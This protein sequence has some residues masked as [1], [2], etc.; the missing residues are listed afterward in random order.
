MSNAPAPVIAPIAGTPALATVRWSGA[1]GAV[2]YAVMRREASNAVE[3]RTATPITATFWNDALSNPASVYH[4][5]VIAYQAD[6]S[7]GTS[8]WTS[9][10]PPPM[11]NPTGFAAR[12][13][14]P[15]EVMLTWQKVT[16]ASEYR[17]DG[18]GIPIAGVT[19]PEAFLDV[20]GLSAGTTSSWQVAAVYG[21]GLFDLTT[22]PTAS[23]TLPASPWRTVPWLTMPNGPGTA[24]DQ[25]AYYDEMVERWS[26]ATN[27]A[28]RC[29]NAEWLVS[30]FPVSGEFLQRWGYSKDI[31]GPTVFEATFAD[32]RDMGAGRHVLC[33]QY[34]PEV[35][36]GIPGL[37]IET[38]CWAST[39][40]PLPGAAGWGDPQQSLDAVLGGN[41]NRGWTFLRTGVK[42]PLFAA[43]EGLPGSQFSVGYG[44]DQYGTPKLES[45]FDA[46][47]PKA[48][49]NA[50]LAC[51]GGR[52]DPAS[53]KVADASL[54]PLDPSALIFPSKAGLTRQDQEESIRNI[55]MIVLN[56]KPSPAV[57]AYIR[58]LYRGTPE[59]PGTTA[60][61][62]YVPTGWSHAPDLYRKVVKPYCQGC[63]L[64][65]T[66]RTD[67]ATYQNFV[68]LKGFIQAL[69]CGQHS[70][71]HAEAPFLGFWR[72]GQG[73]SLPEYMM[74]AL[75]LG[76]CTP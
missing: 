20:P 10:T 29:L 4:Y 73:E 71:P 25:L 12:Q 13:I 57:A 17:V 22:R 39:H 35:S 32:L 41:P 50:C 21:P 24:S 63:H 7:Y 27:P 52:Y 42:G 36:P 49:P 76:K 65:Q 6:G 14:G 60:D 67:F 69:T 33:A 75:G 30:R 46:E 70:M 54:I 31:P 38:L 9:F 37:S 23:I 11:V 3:Q 45:T 58:G 44:A 51:H 16:G 64:Q 72:D 1:T 59:V 53:R 40:G 61:D 74:A 62:N 15:G 28:W 56:A 43:F 68:D 55:N 66:P 18:S 26:C 34:K 5:Q 47:G 8:A 48:V 2:S 19:S